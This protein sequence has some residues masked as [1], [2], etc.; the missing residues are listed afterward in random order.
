MFNRQV[1]AQFDF[2]LR[3]LRVLRLRRVQK[4]FTA[5]AQRTPR[6][7]GEFKLRHYPI[8]KWCLSFPVRLRFFAVFA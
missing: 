4:T 8:A 5:E 2:S 1:A 6:T 3:E 7:R